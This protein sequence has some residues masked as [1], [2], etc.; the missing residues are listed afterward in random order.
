MKIQTTDWEKTLANHV[1]DKGLAPR[2]CIILKTQQKGKPS[3]FFFNGQDL[4]RL[5]QRR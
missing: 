1:S 2:I 3:D 5:I 4:N